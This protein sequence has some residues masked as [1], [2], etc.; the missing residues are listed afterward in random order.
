MSLHAGPTASASNAAA[1]DNIVSQCAL[2]WATISF[3]SVRC[4]L[5]KHE[6]KKVSLAKGTLTPVELKKVWLTVV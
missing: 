4:L 2:G 3:S 1:C 5:I 6:G